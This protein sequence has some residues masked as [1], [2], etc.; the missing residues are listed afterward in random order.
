MDASQ[1]RVEDG[2]LRSLVAVPPARPSAGHPV[3]YFLHGYEEGAPMAM[4]DALTRHGPLR[5]GNAVH[6]IEE[7]LIIAPQLP[8]RGDLWHRHADAVRALLREVRQQYGG[9]PQRS[10]LTGFS[11]GGNGVFDLALR[12][13]DIWAAL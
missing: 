7:F 9:D 2:P 12:Q 10:Y 5:P 6:A 1:L 11:C 3:L 8:T 4:E 13:P